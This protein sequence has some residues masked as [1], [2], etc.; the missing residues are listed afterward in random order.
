VFE[1]R[2]HDIWNKGDA[3]KWILD[4]YD[5]S[6]IPVYIGDDRTDE[7]AFRAIKGKGIG[8]SIGK[9]DTADYYLETQ[10]EVKRLLQWIVRP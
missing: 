9:S 8:I 10:E 2:P 4:S 1:V 5:K 7:D 3:V 6:R